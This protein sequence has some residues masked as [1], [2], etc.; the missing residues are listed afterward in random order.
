[1]L[2]RYERRQLAHIRRT[3]RLGNGVSISL[4]RYEASRT[5]TSIDDL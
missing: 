4:L 5:L 1:M 3:E 2:N